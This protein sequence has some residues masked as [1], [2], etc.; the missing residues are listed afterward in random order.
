MPEKPN[1]KDPGLQ[2]ERT[3]LSWSRTGLLVL[4]V[5]ILLGRS[6]TAAASMIELALTLLLATVAGVFLYRGFRVSCDRSL[7]NDD[8]VER[9]RIL[10]FVSLAIAALAILHGIATA[11]RIVMYLQDLGIHTCQL[12][13]PLKSGPP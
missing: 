6:G 2:P 8:V 7:E 11:G 3:A 1:L 5:A 10:L 9:R 4:L 12:A 13:C